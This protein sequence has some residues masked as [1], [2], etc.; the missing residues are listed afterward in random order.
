MEIHLVLQL[1]ENLFS[2][3]LVSLEPD[4]R[5]CSCSCSNRIV[6]D[7]SAEIHLVLQLIE[8]LFSLSLVS[9]EPDKRSC[10]CSNW[11]MRERAREIHVHVHVQTGSS[12]TA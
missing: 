1:I 12:E 4:K 2:L 6:R 9:L 8:N 10:S 7:S 5:S 3:S 11:I